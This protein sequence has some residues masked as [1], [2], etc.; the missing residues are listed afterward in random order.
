MKL[1]KHKSS[2]NSY[3]V[4]VQLDIGYVALI[5]IPESVFGQELGRK[6][7]LRL[8]TGGNS[9]FATEAVEASAQT[10]SALRRGRWGSS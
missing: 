9:S 10:A 2:L 6:V 7:L 4:T 5:F 1:Q 3:R 8:K